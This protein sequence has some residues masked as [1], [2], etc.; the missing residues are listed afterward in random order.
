M[1]LRIVLLCMPVIKRKISSLFVKVQ[2]RYWMM[3]QQQKRMNILSILLSNKKN[4]IIIGSKRFSFVNGVKSYQFQA[5][6]NDISF[7]LG[8][9]FERCLN[10]A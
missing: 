4:Y 2:Q 7:A 3:Q 9:I 1:Q 8:N 10:L 6:D 5:K